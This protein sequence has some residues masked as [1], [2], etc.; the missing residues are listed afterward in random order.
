MGEKAEEG[1][2]Y[3]NLGNA[4][5]NLSNYPEAI[6]FQNKYLSIA[7]ELC[8]RAGEGDA[9]ANLGNCYYSLGEFQQA[10]EFYEKHL[11]IA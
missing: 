3:G 5:C 4:Y 11:S 2:T 9:Y 1:R 7:K 8:D 6:E 10:I